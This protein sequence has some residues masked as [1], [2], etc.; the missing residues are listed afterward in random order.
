[1]YEVTNPHAH[2]EVRSEEDLKMASFLMPEWC[3]QQKL[4]VVG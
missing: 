2:L 3:K 4:E 1:M